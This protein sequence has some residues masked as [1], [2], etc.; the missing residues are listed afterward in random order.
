MNVRPLVIMNYERKSNW[1]LGENEPNSK[2]IKANVNIGK[3]GTEWQ[4]HIVNFIP[5]RNLSGFRRILCS[6]V[7]QCLC[8]YEPFIQ[9]K[10]NSKPN[11]ANFKRDDGFSAYY[12]RDRHAVSISVEPKTRKRRLCKCLTRGGKLARKSSF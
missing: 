8:G 11:K 10:P 5:I 3:M 2:P 9:N 4:R 6:F 1:T 12:T 7:P